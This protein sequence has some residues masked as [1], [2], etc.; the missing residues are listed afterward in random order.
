[1]T[2]T[3]AT[4]LRIV[5]QKE[6]HPSNLTEKVPKLSPGPTPR[7]CPCPSSHSK[8]GKCSPAHYE[9]SCSGG[10]GHKVGNVKAKLK[11]RGNQ[12]SK[13]TIA[14]FDTPICQAV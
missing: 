12:P 13:F 14:T 6:M 8:R 4:P 11:G 2:T 5:I 10:V 1:M 7:R 3:K 9:V